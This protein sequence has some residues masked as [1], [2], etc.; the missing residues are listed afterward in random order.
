MIEQVPLVLTPM[1]RQWRCHMRGACCKVHRIQ[2]DEREQRIRDI[3]ARV[4][5]PELEAE[6]ELTAGALLQLQEQLSVQGQALQMIM[7]KM[8]V[9]SPGSENT[10]N[11]SGATAPEQGVP[12][13]TV[14]PASA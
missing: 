6:R 1:V 11:S 4:T 14:L 8:G 3:E 9:H 5:N 7:E 12:A 2:V 10:V 13:P